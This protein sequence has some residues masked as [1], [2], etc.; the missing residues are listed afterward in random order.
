MS[1]HSVYEA[2]VGNTH[3]AALQA[4]WDAAFD[5]GVASVTVI[6]APAAFQTAPTV[7]ATTPAPGASTP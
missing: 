3:E 7:A 2:N 5:A 4:V 6:E 1:A